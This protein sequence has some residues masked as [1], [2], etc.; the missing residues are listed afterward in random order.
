MKYMDFF[1]KLEKYLVMENNIFL[2]DYDLNHLQY[3]IHLLG[4]KIKP[5]NRN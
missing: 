5:N 3:C 1:F 4:S 2:N